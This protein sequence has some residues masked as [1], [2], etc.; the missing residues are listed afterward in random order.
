[1]ALRNHLPT[2]ILT[3]KS[4]RLNATTSADRL[5]YVHNKKLTKEK[6]FQS[7]GI[8]KSNQR[9][10][11]LTLIIASTPAIGGSTWVPAFVPA[12]AWAMGSGRTGPCAASAQ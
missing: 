1:M 5:S 7:T 11:E 6:D 12:G 3:G 2:T 10:G 8:K 9:R 4:L